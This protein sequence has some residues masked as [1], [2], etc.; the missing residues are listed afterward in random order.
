MSESFQ[1]TAFEVFQEESD[2]MDRVCEGTGLELSV[3]SRLV[4]A[5]DGGLSLESDRGEGTWVTVRLPLSP[6]AMSELVEEE[7]VDLPQS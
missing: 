7:R 3:V 5:L 4:E 1:E 6:A 2:G